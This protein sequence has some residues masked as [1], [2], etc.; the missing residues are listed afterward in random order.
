MARPGMICTREYLL[1]N[2]CGTADAGT[3]NVVDAHMANLRRKLEENGRRRIVQT[4]RRVG[5]K[6]AME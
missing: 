1:E 4:I 6:L 2:A 3:S 5:Y